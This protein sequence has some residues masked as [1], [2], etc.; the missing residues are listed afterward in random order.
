MI[1]THCHLTF[2]DFA[3][4][5][6]DVLDEAA[7][8]GVTGMITIA[9]TSA[10]APAALQIAE[11]HERIWCSAGIHPLYSDK[12]PHD[13]EELGRVASHPK[14]V[15]WGELG[16]DRHYDRPPFE[17]QLETLHTHLD[18]IR[19]HDERSLPI[20]LHC[21]EAFEELVPI[22]RASRLDPARFVFHCFTGDVGDARLVMDFGAMISFTGVVTYPNAPDVREAARFV[23]DDRI[24]VET[25]APFL[26]PVP[27]RGKRPCR[28]AWV[29]HT[30]RALAVLR[31]TEFDAFHATLNTNTSRFFGID[32]R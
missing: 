2:P 16:L 10:D 26:P 13:W 22:L 9:T 3:S 15:A 8:A 29:L 21:R 25:D 17:L 11:L 24:M 5:V 19:Q 12:G 7:E 14:C 1:D 4:E 23:P 31:E 20:V 32:A 27:H 6:D 18:Y 30:A 28:P